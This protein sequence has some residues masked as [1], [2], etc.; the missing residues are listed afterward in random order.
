MVILRLYLEV[1]TSRRL[2]ITLLTC[3]LIN[4]QEMLLQKEFTQTVVRCAIQM[5]LQMEFTQTVVLCAIQISI[6]T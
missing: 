5:L 4:A 6:S 1:A 2:L 3:V